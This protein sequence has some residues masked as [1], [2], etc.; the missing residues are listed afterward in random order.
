VTITHSTEPRFLSIE[1]QRDSRGGID[2]I[3]QIKSNS[4]S[5]ECRQFF[6]SHTTKANT[7]RGLH[8]QLGDHSERKI[9]YCQSGEL[10]WFSI[11]IKDIEYPSD[12]QTFE[13]HMSEGMAIYLPKGGLNGM[14][15]LSDDVNLM[16]LASAPFSEEYGLNVSP[17]G[18]LFFQDQVRKYRLDS[19]MIDRKTNELEQVE[20]I[21]RVLDGV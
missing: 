20:F 1:T 14:I 7:F 13:L 8:L 18:C 21:E 4:P 5:F 3:L 9:V 12:F 2:K 6:L 11:L 19:A 15:S 10:V 17:F 16:I